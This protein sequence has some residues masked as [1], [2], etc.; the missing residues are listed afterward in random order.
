M[1]RRCGLGARLGHEDRRRGR[2]GVVFALLERI[3]ESDEFSAGSTLTLTVALRLFALAS[4]NHDVALEVSAVRMRQPEHGVDGGVG[5]A[6]LVVV[7]ERRHEL[8]D[9]ASAV[10]HHQKRR[11][12]V[13]E[14]E[15]APD[16]EPELGVVFHDLGPEVILE[17]FDDDRR[18]ELLLTRRR[19]LQLH[20]GDFV[21][22]I[23]EAGPSAGDD[24]QTILQ[25]FDGR[26]RSDGDGHAALLGAVVVPHAAGAFG[27]LRASQ[28]DPQ[29]GLGA[30]P[31][32]HRAARFAA[33]GSVNDAFEGLGRVDPD[34]HGAADAAGLYRRLKTVSESVLALAEALTKKKTRF[35]LDK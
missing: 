5:V 22:G 34:G 3:V 8:F 14:R 25:Q 24:V 1:N 15:T 26:M 29:V 12:G 27:T 16:L 31:A 6:V 13:V 19:Q 23:L 20:D 21:P 9:G 11:I 18:F 17:A 30:A 2:H 7:G 32:L 35:S 28:V 4:A 33:I 10:I